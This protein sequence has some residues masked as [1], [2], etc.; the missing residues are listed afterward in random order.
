M[1]NMKKLICLISLLLLFALLTLPAFAQEDSVVW[2]ISGDGMTL[3][4]G[5]TEYDLY[6][7]GNH[8][9]F[10]PEGLHMVTYI[11]LGGVDYVV[12]TSEHSE[13]IVFLLEKGFYYNPTLHSVYVTDKGKES[14]DRLV[15]AGYDKALFFIDYD[16]YIDLDPSLISRWDSGDFSHTVSVDELGA[17]YNCHEIVGYDVGLGLSHIHGAVYERRSDNALYYLNYDI[18]DNSYFD[19]DGNFSYR[20]GEVKLYPLSEA[21]DE[22]L[23]NGCDDPE[24]FERDHTRFDESYE[25][26]GNRLTPSEARLIFAINW[27]LLLVIPGGIIAIVNFTRAKK[28]PEPKRNYLIACLGA[29]WCFLALLI[30]ILLLI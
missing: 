1:K 13:E 28:K 27:F 17:D 21:D 20:K 7:K 14:L 11:E 25:E 23:R 5:L 6:Q 26:E 8:L 3:D 30:I 9:D 15:S 12:A 22:M 2:E 18:L 10:D 4:N 29:V 16:S 19:A 24:I